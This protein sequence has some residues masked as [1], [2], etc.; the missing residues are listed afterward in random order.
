MFKF[1]LCF[2]LMANFA[3]A[4]KSVTP[5][6]GV[7]IG[8]NPEGVL[9]KAALENTPAQKAGLKA[10]DIVLTIDGNKMTSP[11]QM[12]DY[13]ST[14]GVGHKVKI[15]IKTAQGKIESRS[16]KLVAKP[17]LLDMAIANLKD[18][19]APAIKL[20]YINDLKKNFSL[21]DQKQVT[22]VEFWATWC[23][24]C[25]MAWPQISEFAKKNKN[26]NVVAIAADEKIKLRKYLQQATAKGVLSEEIK[27][28]WDEDKKVTAAYFVPALPMFFVVDE[29]QIVQHIGVGT[30]EEL[31]KVFNMAKKLAK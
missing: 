1:I 30:G 25:A 10:G 27:V 4:Q 6:I 11:S 28:L 22:I 20:P 15:K 12:I 26:I 17:D 29:K 24:A 18:K 31:E 16:L 2:I 14:K 13:V 8:D 5:W 9:I 19:K 7:A 3:F 23:G 21:S